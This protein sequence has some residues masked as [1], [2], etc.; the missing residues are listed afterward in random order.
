MQTTY[1]YDGPLPCAYKFTGKERDSES[2]AGGRPF[3]T[4]Q[5]KT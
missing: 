3:H 1:H 2:G 4:T 5:V